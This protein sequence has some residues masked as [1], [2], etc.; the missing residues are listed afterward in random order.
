MQKNPYLILGLK[1]GASREE[2]D[3]AYIEMKNKYRELR[4]EDGEIGTNAS[5]M[6]DK[7]EIA[8]EDC[9]MD[10]ANRESEAT[11]GSSYGEIES[12][13]KEKKLDEAQ[14]LLDRCETRDA[15]WHYQQANI[16]F[17]KQW[18]SEARTQ[19]E[20]ACDLDSTNQKYKDT[21]ERL[22]KV[23][24]QNAA[25][26]STNPNEEQRANRA[27]YTNP[28][29]ASQQDQMDS[30]A[31]CCNALSCACCADTCCEC[32]GGDCIPCC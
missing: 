5:K 26:A 32:M 23:M 16:Y 10:I 6:L 2:V 11:Y 1:P 18:H 31:A 20:I 25:G 14:D 15:E 8:Y 27:G 9:L 3:N 22:K 29:V 17:K 19:L 4:Y 21:L 24:N 28:N 7:I 12:L 30:S 13:I